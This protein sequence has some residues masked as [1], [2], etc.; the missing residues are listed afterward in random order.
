MGGTKASFQNCVRDAEVRA[1]YV[2]SLVTG[3]HRQYF[4][5]LVEQN[6]TLERKGQVFKMAP[7][8]RD[9]VN[10]SKWSDE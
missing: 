7:G 5:P 2:Y 6:G 9:V 4:Y 1:I 3:E 10:Q 8:A